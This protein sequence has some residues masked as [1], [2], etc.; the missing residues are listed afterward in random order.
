MKNA[1]EYEKIIL[2]TILIGVIVLDALN[3]LNG[4]GLFTLSFGF[5]YILGEYIS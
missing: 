1:T 4:A 3:V 2:A 5:G